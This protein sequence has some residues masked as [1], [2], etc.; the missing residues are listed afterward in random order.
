MKRPI[1]V[2][3]IFAGFLMAFTLASANNI[4][5]TNVSITGQNT[6][7]HYS[8]IKFDISWENSWRTSTGSSNWDAAWVFVKYR[9]NGGDGIWRQ[10]WLDN[11]GNVPAT[12]STIAIGLLSP[13]SAYNATTNPG[14]GAFIFRNAD[15]TGTNTFANTQL[16]WN[17]GANGVADG[18]SI[19][20]QVFAIE[21][22]YVPQ[23]SFFVGSSGTETG[24]FTDGSWVA[25]ATIPLSISSE[26]ALTIGTAAGNLW[27]TSSAGSSTIGSAGT[28]DAA[29]P[30]GFNA[31]YCMK[32]EI[33]QQQYVDFLNNLEQVQATARKY[34]IPATPQRYDISGG[35]VG[36]YVTGNPY[37]AI[38]W[39]SWAD[40]TAYLDWSGLRPMT[41]LEFEKACR[42]TL[43]PIA[44]EYAWG[45]TDL[46]NSVQTLG[47]PGAAT[48]II[49][50]NYSVTLGNATYKASNTSILGPLRVGIFAG[51]P[52]NT[53]RVTAGASYYGI[54]ELS[55]NVL[56]RSV[57]VGNATGRAFTGTHGDGA[58]S[59]AGDADVATWPGT[60]AIGAC[61]RGG[62]Y[63][64]TLTNTQMRISD[65]QFG[66]LTEASRD[67]FADGRGGR[68]VRSAPTP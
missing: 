48:E 36:S 7:S 38:N 19:D 8:L 20:I 52:G 15:G 3:C 13:A 45:T 17:Y 37:V 43:P 62:S 33:T 65:R 49:A 61:F 59:G 26:N 42:G 55:G 1:H 39:L 68:G 64:A 46:A 9:L 56:E 40:L 18:A 51:T 32:Y 4:T 27:G 63:G 14:L 35:A 10:A 12:G 50:T 30:K 66:T 5:V 31:F 34:N 41:E 25:G 29:F 6:G 16:K 67:T 53:G 54:M 11:S 57:S 22:V 23:G 2:L 24:S 28:L 58:I 44:N 47:T 21:M 60:N